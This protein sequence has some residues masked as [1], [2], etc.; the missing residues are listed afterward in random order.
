MCL[1]LLSCTISPIEYA[2]IALMFGSF[3]AVTLTA[4]IREHLKKKRK[5]Q[6]AQYHK[7]T[8]V[9]TVLL[10]DLMMFGTIE[11]EY[12]DETGVLTADQAALPKFG[13]QAPNLVVVEDYKDGDQDTVI[14]L[15]GR[16]YDKKDEILTKMA[17]QVLKEMQF[18]QTE[19]LPELSEI[20]E[21]VAV[22]DFQFTSGDALLII[23][24]MLW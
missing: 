7:A 6:E 16:A 13:N 1:V 11:A 19:D 17:E 9:R 2:I 20:K 23:R 22:T 12:D 3:F 10:T 18:E 15:L 14:R 5:K 24:S 8:H 4:I 21:L